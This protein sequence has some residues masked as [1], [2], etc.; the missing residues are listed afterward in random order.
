M[1]KKVYLVGA[2]PGNKNL[3][4]VRALALIEKA[5][6]IIYDRLAFVLDELNLKP[7]CVKIFVG[8]TPYIKRTKQVD[9]N[10]ILLKQASETK[11]V[12][13]LKGG[14]PY[15]Y[16]RGAEEAQWLLNHQID[17]EV[18]PGI[19]AGIGGIA[20]AGI[21]ITHRDYASSFHVY[22]AHHKGDRDGNDWKQIANIK[23]TV[24]IYMGVRSLKHNIEQ[25]LQ[26]T[27]NK[28][29]PVAIIER[30]SLSDQRVT[31]GTLST[32]VAKAETNNVKAPAIIVIGE[33]V[34]LQ[35][36]LINLKQGLLSNANII[37]TRP[38]DH[39]NS[40]IDK[41]VDLKANVINI[42]VTKI[43][44]CN[45]KLLSDEVKQIKKYNYLIFTSKN[46]INIFFN[47]FYKIHLDARLLSHIKIITIGKMTAQA[48]TKFHLEADI[49]PLHSSLESMWQAIAS[50]LKPSDHVLFCHAANARQFLVEK[51]STSTHLK[52]LITYESIINEPLK[53]KLSLALKNDQKIDI[54]FTCSSIVRSFM[55]LLADTDQS[56]LTKVN[57]FSIGNI[58]TATLKGYQFTNIIQ[59]DEPSNDAIITKIKEYH[60]GS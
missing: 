25:I 51:L 34:E 30:T 8:K 9:I 39:D 38:N 4:T 18:V 7:N 17:F 55:K 50:N 43:K 14:D 40:F 37:V 36:Q 59:A 29:K 35:P 6:V 11:V 12:I 54:V 3:L 22:T 45:E 19:S 53:E 2:G 20:L 42:P 31:K 47:A 16:G 26:F 57:A 24:I 1:S 48:L 23:G 15:V 5:D 58:T 60:H 21:S 32:I 33:V 44:T 13:R 41:L 28:N 52:E 56:F 10:N 27:D 46:A 49:I